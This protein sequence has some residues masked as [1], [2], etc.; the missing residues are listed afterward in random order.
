MR[1]K[2]TGFNMEDYADEL[3]F[4]TNAREPQIEF[5]GDRPVYDVSIDGPAES[6][7]LGNYVRKWKPVLR[8]NAEMVRITNSILV[9][10]E[11]SEL[12]RKITQMVK[13]RQNA[14]N[15]LR[16]AGLVQSTS[17]A[18]MMTR[19]RVAT[20]RVRPSV[21]MDG[22]SKA[23]HDRTDRIV[24]AVPLPIFRTDYT[25]GRRELMSSRRM[26]AP[27]DTFEAGE[28][29]EALVEEQERML[30]NGEARVIVE[31]NAIFGYT[32][33]PARDTA[34]A[35][36]YGGGDF[37]TITN[38]VPT[39]L[40]MVNALALLRYHGPFNFY[41]SVTQYNEMLEYYSDGSVDNAVMRVER[42][43]MIDSVKPSDYLAAGNG[44][45]VQM[46]SNVVEM[47][48]A[49]APENREWESPDGQSL[50]FAAMAAST[51]KLTTDS[52]GNA[53]IAHVTA[54]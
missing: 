15:D 19:W 33:L 21:S 23:D 8:H 16:S 47:Q 5:K 6:G 3:A 2:I 9:R 17:L 29:I 42:L 51:N 34:T 54:A 13:L 46:T 32:N 48:E 53:G 25:F 20:E 41:I 22:R 44:V 11:W 36:A 7:I 38:I 31:G 37:G 28:A 43:P 39:L 12:D 4:I 27:L 52:E 26:G 35:A 45:L 14:I 40:G 50:N 49:L 18:V 24:R 1:A 30:F 10:E